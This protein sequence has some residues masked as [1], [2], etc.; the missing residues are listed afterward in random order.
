MGMNHELIES[1]AEAI[2]R[3]GLCEPAIFILELSK[4]LVGCMR[5]LC[6]AGEP[7]A[8]ALL[9]GSWAPKLREVLASSDSVEALIQCLEQMRDQ[10]CIGAA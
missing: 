10:K 9:G 1:V 5:E 8:S 4:P 6:G 7:I 3:R 2:G